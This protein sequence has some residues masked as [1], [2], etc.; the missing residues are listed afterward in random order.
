MGNLL[1]NSLSSS[2]SFSFLPSPPPLDPC[3]AGARAGFTIYKKTVKVR[4]NGPCGSSSAARPGRRP[5]IRRQGKK[6]TD[7]TDGSFGEKNCNGN[8]RCNLS[9]PAAHALITRFATWRATLCG[10]YNY[11]NEN[12][13]SAANTC[14]LR[15]AR[16]GRERRNDTVLPAICLTIRR[17]RNRVCSTVPGWN[18]L[19]ANAMAMD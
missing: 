13:M 12:I 19:Y 7:G 15:S 3:P 17:N 10:R 9:V 2:S 16:G 1:N 11:E 5:P 4:P 6:T 14:A 8:A 18:S